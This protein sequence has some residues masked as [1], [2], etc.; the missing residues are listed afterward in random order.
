MASLATA[1]ILE[2][3]TTAQVANVAETFGLRGFVG[4]GSWR[5]SLQQGFL[6]LTRPRGSE[7]RQ[8]IRQATS[9]V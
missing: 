2:T 6:K 4:R 1:G 9:S 8:D 7:C 5:A 3:D